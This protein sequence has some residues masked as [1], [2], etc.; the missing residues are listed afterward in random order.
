MNLPDVNNVSAMYNIPQRLKILQ[1]DT[2]FEITL[3]HHW[4]CCITKCLCKL[5][6]NNSCSVFLFPLKNKMTLQGA[7][8]M[9]LS[10]FQDAFSKNPQFCSDQVQ[11]SEFTCSYRRFL[12]VFACGRL[13]RISLNQGRATDRRILTGRDCF[14]CQNFFL[15]HATWGALHWK[16]NQWWGQ[17]R[18]Q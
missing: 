6:W 16:I 17:Q 12:Q 5:L 7:G 11:V 2:V 8:A 14:R 13:S 18:W 15:G 4:P 10:F 3:Q 9:L 1:S